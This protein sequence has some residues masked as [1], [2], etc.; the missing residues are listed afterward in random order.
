MRVLVVEDSAYQRLRIVEALRASSAITEVDA[1]GSGEEAIRRLLT[2]DYA[3]VTL[4]LGL[5]GMDGNAVLRWIMA[6]RPVPVVVISA[7]QEE[8]S[9][10]A[11]LEAGALEVIAKAGSQPES[12]ARW[13]RRLA[14]VVDGVRQL[15]IES[16]V[17]RSIRSGAPPSS[18]GIPRPRRVPVALGV[19]PALVV[20][21][22]T[23]GPPALRELFA[24]LPP[25]EAVVGVAQHM[26]PPFTRSLAHRLASGT[27]WDVRE[28]I[29]GAE[30]T[31]G[32]VW[33][34]PGGAHLELSHAGERAVLVVRPH[35][36]SVRWCPSADL[37]FTSAAAAFGRRVVGVVL[38]GMGDD[39]AEGCRSIA[40]AG[41]TVLCESA[42]SAVISGMPDAAARAVPAARRFPLSRLASEVE[43]RLGEAAGAAA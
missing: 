24:G 42:E 29:H 19:P 31:P 11:A 6:N 9:A 41:G 38:T 39:G 16:L 15:S 5:P 32:V 20:A 36:G 14:E 8:R 7:D 3:L 10:L 33:I 21:A 37:L 43:R 28:A 26:P 17:R 25:Q 2:T 40:L 34:A 12:L 27:G 4:D 13:K 23:G 22:S 30:A 1:V 35:G 18:G